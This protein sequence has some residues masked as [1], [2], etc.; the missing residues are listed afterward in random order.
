M[1][2]LAKTNPIAAWHAA[3]AVRMA[4]EDSLPGG[5][6]YHHADGS[7][8]PDLAQRFMSS[9]M[10]IM[11]PPITLWQS[12]Q[13][14]RASLSCFLYHKQRYTL[15][16][17]FD[18]GIKLDQEMWYSVTPE[19]IAKEQARKVKAQL[20][21][22]Q[23]GAV[24]VDSFC[25]AGGSCEPRK[26]AG[27]SMAEADMASL[28]Q[29]LLLFARTALREELQSFKESLLTDLRGK[30]EEVAAPK[31]RTVPEAVH[32][33]LP[34]EAAS[35]TASTST[36]ARRGK[37]LGWGAAGSAS[38]MQLAE[39]SEAESSTT[40][41]A[42]PQSMAQHVVDSLLG[43]SSSTEAKKALERDL[44]ATYMRNKKAKNAG[45]RYMSL[46]T[47][48][49]DNPQAGV[50]TYCAPIRACCLAVMNS[51]YFDVLS[52]W[53][54]VFN[55]VW[56]GLST[57]WVARN[58]ST[59]MPFWFHF[60]DWIFCI[61]AIGELL[62]RM[63]AQ[64]LQFFYED[65]WKWNL[66]D[67][68]VVFTQVADLGGSVLE[69][70][71]Q[72]EGTSHPS[73]QGLRVLKLVRILRIARI[74]S[75][76][77]ELHIL[78]SSIMDSLQSL[79][80]TM[81]LIFACLYAVAVVLTQLVSDHKIAV[82]KEAMEEG[83][84]E[85]LEFFGSLDTTMIS[86]YMV[87]SEGIH[88]KELMDPLVENLGKWVRIVFVMFTGFELFAMMNIITACFVDSAMKIAANAEKQ[89][90][91]D[92]LWGL[93]DDEAVYDARTQKKVVT[94]E[95]FIG[96][97]GE[98]SM[99]K[100]LDLINAHTE[101]PKQV[102][103]MIDRDGD[104]ALTAPEFLICCERLMGPSKASMLVKIANEQRLKMEQQERQIQ[105]IGA[106]M[107]VKQD[108]MLN[109]LRTNIKKARGERSTSFQDP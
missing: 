107:K 63:C 60:G 74:A 106:E 68:I 26:R 51:H 55:A 37:I 46:E 85:M 23:G 13:R 61:L 36:S 4:A 73:I 20:Q 34:K 83:G 29:E 62:I 93:L 15:F 9:S 103:T 5:D 42:G 90:C 44:K 56:I 100:F 91:L 64:G 27:G 10:P 104:G 38:S 86:L 31:H 96:S 97:Y 41:R 102:F 58:W 19:P 48:D 16:S 2:M 45:A 25:G 7:R 77:P 89:E 50:T 32:G 18:K 70:S 12:L 76:F 54:V 59:D 3:E 30:E 40:R 98:P 43:D 11:L 33:A 78:I 101:D 53:M 49:L 35:S 57:D 88:W 22:E 79:F 65:H 99:T 81:I 75:V 21:N 66:F 14:S 6:L 69:R 109:I 82:G 94:K 71:A 47:S 67:T 28:R 92:S 95:Q 87:I 84:E 80:W 39:Q 72:G 108:E 24:L 105:K 52:A 17:K 1:G 8:G